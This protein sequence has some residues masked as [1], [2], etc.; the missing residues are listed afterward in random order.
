MSL[1]CL[2]PIADDARR[3]LPD[4][5]VHD[6]QIVR[7]KV[8]HHVRIMLEETEVHAHG[9]EVHDLAQTPVVHQFLDLP[10]RARVHER[11]VHHQCQLV[12]VCELD[13]FLAMRGTFGHRL[14]EQHVLPCL[15]GLQGKRMMR[16][17]RGRDGD[18]SDILAC[19]K[20]FVRLCHFQRREL[21]FGDGE[22]FFRGVKADDSIH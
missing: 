9:V 11:V 5:V 4:D 1:K 12:L 6:R 7:C 20:L 13:E 16:G 3:F 18:R 22:T 15:E 14:L 17:D 19:K 21:L 8:P 2:D 10:D